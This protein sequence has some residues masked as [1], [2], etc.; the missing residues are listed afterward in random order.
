MAIVLVQKDPKLF[1]RLDE[2]LEH[3]RRYARNEL[4]DKMTS[5]GFR[6]ERVIEFNRATR[7]GW[8]LNSKLLRRSTISPMQLRFFD[9]LV[10]MWKRID[11]SLPWPSNSLIAIG[12]ADD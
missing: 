12:V 9:L 7:P 3:K 4:V 10:P 1:G 2:V 5:A 6:V 11:G 8:Y